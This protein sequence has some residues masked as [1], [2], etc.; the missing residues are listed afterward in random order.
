MNLPVIFHA[1]R[2]RLKGGFTLL[3]LL[4]VCSLALI[5]G[6]MTLPF[7]IAFFRAQLLNEAQASVLE[8]LREAQIYAISGK[9]NSAQGVRFFEHSLVRFTGE[10]YE[11][12]DTGLDHAVAFSPLISVD[13]P[14]EVVYEPFSG[15]PSA[16]G[17][18]L[19]DLDGAQRNIV[20]SDTGSA[21]Q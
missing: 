1:D 15:T 21:I 16:T 4:L 14:L 12:R 11:E 13:A 18:I 7:G 6:G 2:Q 20:I 17:T 8:S 5:I 19:L 3:E 9:L 10:S